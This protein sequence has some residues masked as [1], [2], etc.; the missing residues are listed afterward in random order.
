MEPGTAMT[1]TSNAT[2]P[3]TSDTQPP[4]P[5]VRKSW[6]RRIFGDFNPLRVI[7]GFVLAFLV[8]AA[9]ASAVIFFAAAQFQSRVA[10]LSLNGAPMTI[11]RVDAFRVEFKDWADD[12]RQQ[13]KDI[14]QDRINLASDKQKNLVLAAEQETVEARLGDDARSL[15][16]RIVAAS[17]RA[18]AP[19][20]GPTTNI[21]DTITQIELLL[22]EGEL[23]T[24]FGDEFTYLVS[25]HELATH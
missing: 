16:Q 19:I 10:E 4:P 23:R 21:S 15:K 13:R 7:G 20:S 17:P 25:V 2:N 8:I 6:G 18:I 5:E 14:T 24:R 3:P 11:W 22:P 12:I 9:A 1:D